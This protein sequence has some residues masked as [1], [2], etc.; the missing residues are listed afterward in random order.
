MGSINLA[1]HITKDG[2]VDWEKLAKTTRESTHFLD[3]VVSVNSYVPA[4]P[5]LRESA[6]SVR[7]I[8]LG[9][10]GLG[11][12]FYELGIRYGGI[13]SIDLAS[14]IMEFVRYHSMRTSVDLAMER[15][16]FP[17]FEGS[18]YSAD[19]WSPP[20]RAKGIRMFDWGRPIL[21]WKI[22]VHGI[23]RY[24]IRN[25]EQTTIAP[26]GTIATVCG[27]EGYGCEPV[28]ALGYTRHFIDGDKDVELSYVSPLFEK[29]LAKLK[30]DE[31]IK[32]TIRDLI[33]RYGNCQGITDLP[34]HIKN[35]FVVSGDVEPKNHVAMQAALQAFTGN[36]ISK[37]CN[38]PST[39]TENDVK[40]IYTMA[41]RLGCK[42]ITVY[43][44]GS[45]DKV[46]LETNST[47]Q[48]KPNSIKPAVSNPVPET[49]LYGHTN[50]ISTSSGKVYLTVNGNG[51]PQETFVTVGKGGT[52]VN[53]MA[54][55]IGRLMSL[56]LQ[57]N[58]QDGT[59]RLKMIAK[60]LIGIGG[61]QHG[62]GK[63]KVL[64]LPD[65]IGQLIMNN[66][67]VSE[68]NNDVEFCPEC[69]QPTL[70]NQEGCQKCFECGYSLC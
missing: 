30:I 64:S 40:E 33:S 6:L 63:S 43:V 17:A 8:G 57:V 47:K 38:L 37:T 3:N 5:E 41:W 56:T 20:Q 4:V 61:R 55:A 23:K 59:E 27:I 19:K 12:L 39:A 44:E 60:Q 7:R 29:S 32:S 62:V 16:R 58:G 65:A 15:G 69:G 1:E 66:I 10:M 45:R 49:L 70:V 67:G 26:T 28:F 35:V 13:K 21:D 54:E 50:R 53:A 14:Q 48:S 42:G 25:A 36:A 24:G 31:S 46:V 22:V 52:E 68:D 11:D 18:I 51:N 2:C 9:I 34:E